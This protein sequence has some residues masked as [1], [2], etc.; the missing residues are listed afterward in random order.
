MI[1]LTKYYSPNF[2]WYCCSCCFFWVMGLLQQKYSLTYSTTKFLS[3]NWKISDQSSFHEQLQYLKNILGK[4]DVQWRYLLWGTIICKRVKIWSNMYYMNP[5]KCHFF[6]YNF[7]RHVHISITGKT[8]CLVLNKKYV[9]MHRTKIHTTH[10]VAYPFCEK[11]HNFS[12]K[13]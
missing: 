3:P 9:H 11:M 13:L 12:H 8:V 7:L 1:I 6:S 5:L 2:C 10:F 4:K